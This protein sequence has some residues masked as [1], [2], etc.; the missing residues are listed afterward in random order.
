MARYSGK[1]GVA[2]IGPTTG[3]AAIAVLGLSKWTLNQDTDKQECTAFQD[4]N[5]QYVQGLPDVKG[6]VSGFWDDVSS[7]TLFTAQAAA[8]GVYCYLYPSTLNSTKYW[9]G[10]AFFDSQV[11]VDVGS[12]VK[13]TS[14]FVGSSNWGRK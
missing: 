10:S 13:V 1:S 9:Y 7:D 8:G 11:E 12:A 2:Y 3:G 5:K 6:S 4:T 14:N